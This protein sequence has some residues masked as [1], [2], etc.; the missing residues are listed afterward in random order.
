MGTSRAA[1]LADF[2]TLSAFRDWL[3][4]RSAATDHQAGVL[5]A[6]HHRKWQGDS[7]VSVKWNAIL[8]QCEVLQTAA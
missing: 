3:T 2:G 4:A 6:A 5:I 8:D 7:A 1:M